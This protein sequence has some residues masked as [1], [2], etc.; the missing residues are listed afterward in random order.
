MPYGLSR[1]DIESRFEQSRCLPL[2]AKF[3]IIGYRT[4]CRPAGGYS[5]G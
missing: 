5:E 3:G 1:L 4:S 2:D